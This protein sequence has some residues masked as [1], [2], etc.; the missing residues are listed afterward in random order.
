MKQKFDIITCRA[1][2]HIKDTIRVSNK[3]TKPTTRYYFYKGTIDKAMEECQE[4]PYRISISKL[5]VPFLK[6]ERHLLIYK[7]NLK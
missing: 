5:D 2:S 7:K 6:A 3:M 1:F 4:L